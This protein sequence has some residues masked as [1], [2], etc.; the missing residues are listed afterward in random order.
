MK[1]DSSVIILLTILFCIGLSAQEPSAPGGRVAKR[2][3]DYDKN[4]D[5]KLTSDEVPNKRLFE[6]L[7]KNRDGVVTQEEVQDYITSRRKERAGALDGAQADKTG[8]RSF[9]QL[10]YF[11]DFVCGTKD[12]NGNW[13]HGTETMR[14]VAHKGKLFAAMGF[15]MDIP[16]LK[17]KGER[18]WTGSQV[19]VKE[20]ADGQWR[21]DANFGENSVRVDAMESLI[22]TTDSSGKKL[23]KP[24]TLLVACPSD[25]G[26]DKKSYPQVWVRDDETGKWSRTQIVE[27]E[28]RASS[29]RSVCTHID[30]VTGV[31]HIFAGVTGQIHR[32]VYDPDVEGKLR[33]VAEPELTGFGRVM[34]FAECNSVLYASTG[35]KK[36]EDG[37]VK[38][39]IY[40]RIDGK[41]P[42][43]ELVWQWEHIELESG[44]EANILRGLTKLRTLEGREV[45][46][47][48]HRGTVYRIEPQEDGQHKIVKELDIKEYFA[49]VWGL[50]SY[51]GPTLTAYNRCVPFKNPMNG[52]EVLLLGTWV[53]HPDY[54]EP[55]HSGAYFLIRRPS[56]SYEHQ[57]IYDFSNPPEKGKEIEATRT[58]EISPFPEDEGKVLYFGGYDCAGRESHNTAWIYKGRMGEIQKPENIIL[59]SWDGLDRSVLE[60]LLATK[61]LPN[62]IE[63][64]KEGS[65]Q[66]ID[67]YEHSTVTK[68]SHAVILTGLEPKTTGVINNRVFKPIPEGYTIFERLR[69]HF[70]KENIKT[71]FVASKVANVGG[72]GPEEAK[73]WLKQKKLLNEQKLRKKRKDV[74]EGAD[75][76]YEDQIEG[77][78]FYLTRKNL[79]VF[80]SE[81][82]EA[83]ETGELC[84]KYLEQVKSSNFF[85][86]F[87]FADPDHAGHKYGRNSQEYRDAAV[88]CDEWLGKIVKWLKDQNLYEKTLIY[89]TTDHGFDKDAKSHN[90]APHCWLVTNDKAVNHGGTL[91][92]IPATILV[93]LGV[94]LE[95]LTPKIVGRPLIVEKLPT[96]TKEEFKSP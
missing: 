47:G 42:K 2:F 29:V 44:D 12:V 81:Q 60:E 88:L 45:L 18:P 26:L 54:P 39:G 72:R 19:L 91:Y 21:V 64:I 90:Y 57:L 8:S 22:F 85:A 41:E 7:D 20:S 94:D 27:V 74:P 95:N 1:K 31:H 78:P 16:Y 70:G 32:G 28:K 30:R 48:T 82:R 38:G 50:D 80:D 55:P 68:P 93:R 40:K 75:D 35:T 3:K 37:S 61:R 79:D 58:I 96:V 84:L 36:Q 6:R 13:M 10:Q 59:F 43:W 46:I 34:A 77:E 17:P 92:D 4:G 15:W 5:G 49:K 63:L 65:Y 14:L 25:V 52:E 56:G 76:T 62:S 51:K 69:E 9:P 87:H 89:V 11:K 71:I 23:E 33:W 24:V 83:S 67:I 86:F 53:K 73:E 66:E